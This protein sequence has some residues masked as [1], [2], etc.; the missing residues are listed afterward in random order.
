MDRCRQ[1]VEL[2]LDLLRYFDLTKQ[3]NWECR[4]RLKKNIELLETNYFRNK[5]LNI[6]DQH[7]GQV[8][9]VLQQML[10]LTT[11]K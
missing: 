8:A 7:S 1:A 2:N 6:I 10:G 11:D 4:D 5:C 9:P 3:I